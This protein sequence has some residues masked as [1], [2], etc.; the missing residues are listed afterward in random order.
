MLNRFGNKVEELLKEKG[1]T[2]YK[3]A[4]ETGIS[5]SILSD[6][7]KGTVQ[8]TADIIIIVAKYFEVSTD[9]ILGVEDESGRRTVVANSFN[10]NSGNI[11]FR[12]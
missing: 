3:L 5:K 8:P 2:K 10:G 7:C 9:Y 12:G 4:K 1:M 6:Y 11:S